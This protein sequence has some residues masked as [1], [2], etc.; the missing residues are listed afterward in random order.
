MFCSFTLLT[1]VKL[2]RAE[3][4]IHMCPNPPNHEKINRMNGKFNYKLSPPTPPSCI[5]CAAVPFMCAEDSSTIHGFSSPWKWQKTIQLKFHLSVTSLWGRFLSKSSFMCRCLPWLTYLQRDKG[6]KAE[7]RTGREK[8]ADST[9]QPDEL[10]YRSGPRT[11]WTYVFSFY[12]QGLCWE[13]EDGEMGWM[14][15]S[16]I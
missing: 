10:D 7:S 3:K 15:S 4:T 11:D 12:C 8:S 16:L 14:E 13:L 1:S 9:L 6:R 2:N 5:C